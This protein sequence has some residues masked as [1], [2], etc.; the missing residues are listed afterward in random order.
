MALPKTSGRAG[1]FAAVTLAAAGTSF[2]SALNRVSL[3]AGMEPIWI[4]VLRL[5]LSLLLTLALL[6]PRRD[7]RRGLF[8]MSKKN[9][10][11]SALSGVLLA[12]HFMG[13]VMA[14]KLA[15]TFVV[16]SV[17]ST[18]VLLAVVGSSIALKERTAPAALVGLVIAVVGVALGGLGAEKSALMGVLFALGSA[19][20]QAAYAVVGR[21][22]RRDTDALPYTAVVYASAAGVLLLCALVFQAPTSGFTS[23]GVGGALG[24]AVLCTLFGHSLASYALKFLPAPF[25]SAILL[26]EVVMGPL[27]VYLLMG[28]APT[29]RGLISG[30]VILLGVGV[31]VLMEL[32][33]SRRAE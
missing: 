13:W 4:N 24:L 29:L 8:R 26:T 31:Y 23:S 15:N 9:L 30:A 22:V 18:Y 14:L 5:G 12:A 28:E 27:I 10:A 21:F 3:G 7:L 25:V 17:W 16:T 33:S 20:A 11:L 2:S 19:A 32:R 6:L 1:G